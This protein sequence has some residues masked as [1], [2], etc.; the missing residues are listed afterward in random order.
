MKTAAGSAVSDGVYWSRTQQKQKV[1]PHGARW[2]IAQ[3]LMS[4][5]PTT[6]ISRTPGFCSS[7]KREDVEVNAVRAKWTME[8]RKTE[9]MLVRCGTP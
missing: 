9:V 7:R 6:S 4:Q 3:G 2:W 8:L 5:T 1:S